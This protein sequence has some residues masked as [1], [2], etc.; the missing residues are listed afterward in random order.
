MEEEVAFH[1]T[2]MRQKTDLHLDCVNLSSTST[3]PHISLRGTLYERKA[4]AAHFDRLWRSEQETCL[5]V[6]A[7]AVCGRQAVR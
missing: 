3:P 5:E 7:T 4:Q 2:L 1:G 6:I